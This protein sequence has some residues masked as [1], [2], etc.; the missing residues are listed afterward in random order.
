MVI[1]SRE[2]DATSCSEFQLATDFNC[3]E[4]PTGKASLKT[5][6]QSGNADKC[7]MAQPDRDAFQ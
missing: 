7:I 6:L 1:A 4:N 2:N 5:S 3:V